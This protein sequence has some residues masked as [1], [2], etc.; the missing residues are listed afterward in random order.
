M[1]F[2]NRI[3]LAGGLALVALP[4]VAQD[5]GPRLSAIIGD[6]EQRGYRVTEVDVDNDQ[7]EIQAVHPDGHT[8]EATVDPQSGAVLNETPDN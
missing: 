1:S 6:F 4:A 8:V 5:A 3:A 7:I 2:T